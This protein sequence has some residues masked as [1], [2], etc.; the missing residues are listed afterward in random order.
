MP[1]SFVRICL[2]IALL[3]SSAA[4]TA[5]A[6]RDSLEALL[7]RAERLSLAAAGADIDR[8]FLQIE[9][10]LAQ[11][12]PRQRIEFELIRI[13]H[14]ARSGAL[15]DAADAIVAMID[16]LD[17][18]DKDLAQRTLNLAT[19][20]LVVNGQFDAGFG[21]F[22]RALDRVPNVQDPIMRAG[23]YSVAAELYDRIGE[24]TTALAYADR[25]LDVARE[26]DLERT[27]CIALERGGRAL[28]GAQRIDEAEARFRRA[29]DSCA[30]AGERVFEA[31]AWMGL[32]QS[33]EA[34]QRRRGCRA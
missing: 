29:I 13:R 15:D 31:Q 26:H 8:L 11:A 2:L 17:E 21:Y 20:I 22:R 16:G 34:R 6:E 25:A 3:I 30:R 5:Q 12:T 27:A 23:T 19:N 9:P 28:L 32:G 4:S 14:A 1:P 7:E 33:L 10:E 24:T 18:M